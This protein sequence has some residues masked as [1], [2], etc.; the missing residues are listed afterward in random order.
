[1]YTHEKS[2]QVFQFN[3]YFLICYKHLGI[4]VLSCIS[5][6]SILLV[7][8]RNLFIDAVLG[9]CLVKVE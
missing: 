9:N 8:K 4:K 3:P 2:A 1:M 6:N 5:Q 7:K